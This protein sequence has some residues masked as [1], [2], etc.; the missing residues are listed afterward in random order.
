MRAAGTR[1]K[2]HFARARGRDVHVDKEN[3]PGRRAAGRSHRG[4]RKQTVRDSLSAAA[5]GPGM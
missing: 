4:P 2:G 3:Q 5:R 1:L